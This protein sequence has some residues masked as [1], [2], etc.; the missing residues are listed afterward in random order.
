MLQICFSLKKKRTI[1]LNGIR[2]EG[3][4][5]IINSFSPSDEK[6]GKYHDT[7]L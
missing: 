3:P 5:Q 6:D 1:T 7:V 2:V 4:L